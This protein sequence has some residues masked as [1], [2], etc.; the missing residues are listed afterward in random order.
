MR[1]HVFT[2]GMHPLFVVSLDTYFFINT[3]KFSNI[4]CPLKQ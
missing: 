4:Y 2:V 3:S 1:D